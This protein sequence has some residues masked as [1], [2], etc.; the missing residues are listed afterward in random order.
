MRRVFWLA[1]GSS[2]I[3][4]AA[5]AQSPAVG[6]SELTL[7]DTMDC[8]QIATPA[9]TY[10]L[11]KKGAG[12]ARLIDK[13]GHDWISYRPDGKARGEYR[14]SPKC[15]QPTKFFHCG[16]GYGQYQTENT[17]DSRVTLQEAAHVRVESITKDKKTAGTWD[18]FPDH[19]TFTLLRIDIP[20]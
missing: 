3:A 1:I 10:V 19:A 8:F 16:Y 17:F 11:G 5:W 9:A 12:L 13:E 7:F 6:L 18:F 4:S 2:L 15:G 14:G 20:T